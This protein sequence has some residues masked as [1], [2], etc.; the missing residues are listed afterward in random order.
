MAVFLEEVAIITEGNAPRDVDGE[1]AD[2]DAASAVEDK[3]V[4]SG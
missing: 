2:E 3:V 4:A 1:H